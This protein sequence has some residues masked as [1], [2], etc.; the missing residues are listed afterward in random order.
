M[1]QSSHLAQVQN[2]PLRP[3]WSV[4]WVHRGSYP[5]R[6][7]ATRSSSWRAT[8]WVTVNV[9]DAR[10]KYDRTRWGGT[11]LSHV[12]PKLGSIPPI[13]TVLREVVSLW[14]SGKITSRRTF[15]LLTQLSP[16]WRRST[17]LNTQV[18]IGANITITSWF[19]RIKRE[20]G[21]DMVELWKQL[22]D[23]KLRCEWN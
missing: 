3:D 13:K 19:E 20:S 17:V 21:L 5:M 8:R 2:G 11:F 9:N 1:I 23:D 22:S 6:G 14:P 18:Y 7:R 16:S 10:S 12:P 4:W 15:L